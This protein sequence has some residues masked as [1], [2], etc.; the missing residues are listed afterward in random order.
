MGIIRSRITLFIHISY[1]NLCLNGV[2]ITLLQ[3]WG[4]VKSTQNQSSIIWVYYSRVGADVL[5]LIVLEYTIWSTQMY[6]V[7]VYS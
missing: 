6:L 2:I 3:Y 5:I 7:L 4:D 1:K